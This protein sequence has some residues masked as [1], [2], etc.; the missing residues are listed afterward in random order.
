MI[1]RALVRA[2]C[3]IKRDQKRRR[4]RSSIGA[5]DVFRTFPA[6]LQTNTSGYDVLVVANGSDRGFEIITKLR[7]L[8][9]K[10]AYNDSLEPVYAPLVT[11]GQETR[12]ACTWNRLPRTYRVNVG[13]F[14]RPLH[15]TCAE[16]FTRKRALLC[17]NRLTFDGGVY[18]TTNV[19]RVVY[20]NLGRT[21]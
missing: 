12:R 13:N 3:L 7:T 14:Y 20:E 6:S 21:S 17:T 15:R 1:R 18:G 9:S 19:F 2:V 16:R 5:R 10:W 4:N 8:P 11:F